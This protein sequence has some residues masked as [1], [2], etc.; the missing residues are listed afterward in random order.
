MWKRK[1][2]NT[3]EDVSV[4]ELFEDFVNLDVEDDSKRVPEMND[5]DYVSMM[6]KKDA[7]KTLEKYRRDEPIEEPEESAKKKSAQPVI[8]EK[9]STVK[10]CQNCYFSVQE[11]KLSG[12]YWCHCTN[13]GRSTNVVSKGSWVKSQLNLPCWKPTQD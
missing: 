6:L 9:M 5:D 4:A 7:K 12:S 2:K 1:K 13:I 3:M 8:S 10:R 11:K